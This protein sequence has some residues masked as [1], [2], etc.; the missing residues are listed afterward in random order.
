MK[1]NDEAGVSL[2]MLEKRILA[3]LDSNSKIS[4]L[5]LVRRFVNEGIAEE[6][7]IEAIKDLEDRDEIELNE[8]FFMYDSFLQYIKDVDLNFWFYFTIVV[9]V[10]TLIMVFV[11]PSVWP[12]VVIRWVFG[13]LFILFLPG[14]ALVNALFLRR[15]DLKDIERLAL[16]VGLSLAITPLTGFLLNYTIFG[17]RLIPIIVS[18]SIFILGMN[19][20]AIYRKFRMGRSLR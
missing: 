2:E 17:I 19:F 12:F 10:G 20:L 3:I 8:N 11:V 5:D 16:S 7:V 15:G 6:R 14:Y 13:S 9:V 1:G 4:T 18:L